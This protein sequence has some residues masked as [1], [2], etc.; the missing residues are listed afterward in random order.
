M[1]RASAPDVLELSGV[2]ACGDKGWLAV[3]AEDTRHFN[4]PGTER[5]CRLI[6]RDGGQSWSEPELVTVSGVGGGVPA[7]PA[8]V[9]LPDGR[10][11]L[12]YAIS[13][14]AM[15]PPGTR[16]PIPDLPT[17]PPNRP[18]PPPVPRSPTDP[19]PRSPPRPTIPPEPGRPPVGPRSGEPWPVTIGS[20][21][22][23]DGRNFT[24]EEG[25]RM[26]APGLSA[27]DVLF[28]PGGGDSGQ[29]LMFCASGDRVKLA[30]SRDGL[31]FEADGVFELTGAALTGPAA[32]VLLDGRVRVFHGAGARTGSVVYD[33]RTQRIE[34]E[35]GSRTRGG[36]PSVVALAAGGYVMVFRDTTPST[37]P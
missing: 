3:Y 8:A 17:I 33:P 25:T 27:P 18:Q 29:W 34:P 12:Y 16:P 37:V 4:G 5:L 9:Q 21:V 26:Q 31:R 30:R 11:R 15:P 20:A 14:G 22:S 2:G 28:W 1:L 36:D 19:P 23:E 10:I 24:V 13:S 7:D 32:V 35:P 6:S